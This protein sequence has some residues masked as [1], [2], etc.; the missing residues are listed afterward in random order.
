VVAVSI[1][2]SVT[3]A[4]AVGT[5]IVTVAS[6]SGGTGTS[7]AIGVSLSTASAGASIDSA[8]VESGTHWTAV[9]VP[10]QCAPVAHAGLHAETHAP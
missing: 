7:V 6:A 8:S 2:T 3:G 10:V 1:G 5:S 4:S 9:P